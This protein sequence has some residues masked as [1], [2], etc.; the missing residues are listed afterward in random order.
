[1]SFES[2]ARLGGSVIYLDTTQK[3][4]KKNT[5]RKQFCGFKEDMENDLFSTIVGKQVRL[6]V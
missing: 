2:V 3:S 6:Q 4:G 1:M 5:R